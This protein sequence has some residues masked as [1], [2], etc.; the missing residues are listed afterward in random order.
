MQ[1]GKTNK[2]TYYYRVFYVVSYSFNTFIKTQFIPHL[3]GEGILAR[4]R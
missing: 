4:K 1:V 3:R 2:N